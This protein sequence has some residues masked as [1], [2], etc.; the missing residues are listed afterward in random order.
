M[1]ALASG[2]ILAASFAVM[3]LSV[4]ESI[5]EKYV[6]TRMGRYAFSV[7]ILAIG[8]LP[9]II[10]AFFIRVSLVN[11]STVAIAIISG[12]FLG[13][14]YPLFYMSMEKEQ[15]TKVSSLTEI[16]PTIIVVAGLLIFG[17]RISLY[18]GIGM[19]LI[20]AGVAMLM[21]EERMKINRN[22]LPAVMANVCWGLYWVI[23]AFSISYGLAFIAALM[24][25]RITAAIMTYYYAHRNSKLPTL[26]A[27]IHIL[28]TKRLMYALAVVGIIDG[29]FNLIFGFVTASNYL[30]I[31]GSI[32]AIAPLFVALLGALI[33]RDRLRALQLAGLFVVIAGSVIITIS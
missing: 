23:I 12:L 16:Q 8:I 22:L 1:G 10:A 28:T 29:V 7:S 25:A 3:L 24:V 11:Y 13:A 17:E 18:H 26:H 2:F 5:M 30:A 4:S 32:L 9:M 14:G 31:G 6:A 20:F 27:F 19:V 15:V 33:Y 21:A